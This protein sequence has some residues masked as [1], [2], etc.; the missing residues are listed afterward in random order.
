MSDDELTNDDA[1]TSGDQSSQ[2]WLAQA[3]AAQRGLPRSRDDACEDAC[4]EQ[5][6][7]H[8]PAHNKAAKAFI[9][10]AKVAS[11]PPANHARLIFA[12]D[13]TASRQPTWDRA[14]H[15]Q[16]KMFEAT[17]TLGGLNV[18]LCYFR[19][20]D[21]F[22]VSPWLHAAADLEAKMRLVSC[23]GGYTQ[24]E[25]LMR[26]ALAYQQKQPVRAVVLVGDAVEEDVDMLCHLAGKMGQAGL[27]LYIFQEGNDLF[28]SQAMAQMAR[29]SRGTHLQLKSDSAQALASLL[30]AVAAWAAGG[31]QA[32]TSY[33]AEQQ[34]SSGRN[35]LL[36]QLG[37]RLLEDLDSKET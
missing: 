12:M 20:Y 9:T 33:L 37:H 8:T 6:H 5:D 34:A 11:M 30:G 28:A 1:S 29:L 25:K 31:Q 17:S 23:L 32:L 15:I 36:D 2:Q 35:L 13:A 14:M 21:E 22:S 7:S 19:G 10:A 24:I 4:K 3:N 26:H 27:P 16:A 18:Q